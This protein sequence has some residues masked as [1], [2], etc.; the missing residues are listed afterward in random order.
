MT[1]ELVNQVYMIGAFQRVA[2]EPLEPKFKQV[3]ANLWKLG[4]FKDKGQP[5]AWNTIQHKFGTLMKA[6]KMKHG[7][8][9]E[10]ERAN[11]SALP[12]DSSPVDHG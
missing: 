5:V 2:N 12:E 1:L 6:F 8:G 11:L 4:I 10:G 9:D 3:V 7:Y